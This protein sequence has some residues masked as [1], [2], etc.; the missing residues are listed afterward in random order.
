MT[1]EITRKSVLIE[2][3]QIMREELNICSSKYNGLEPK[4][5]MEEA[6]EQARE[7][8][9]ILQALIPALESEPVKKALAEWA[10][11]HYVPASGEHL[12]TLLG[13][14]QMDRPLFSQRPENKQYTA[15]CPDCGNTVVYWYHNIEQG[16]CLC[17]KCLNKFFIV[18]GKLSKVRRKDYGH[19]EADVHSDQK[20]WGIPGG[21]SNGEPG[22]E[23]E[24]IRV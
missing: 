3:L 4:K 19:Q 12:F 5:G 17:G 15:T 16:T 6:W 20:E 9:R 13:E 18:D 21:H 1:G 23:M 2:C 14:Y 11:E 24:P 22:P 8:V 10:G 7:K